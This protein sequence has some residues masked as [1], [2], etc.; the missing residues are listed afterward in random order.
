[1]A[2]SLKENLTLRP[3]AAETVEQ[4]AAALSSIDFTLDLAA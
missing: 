3:L 2:E 4:L 1:M